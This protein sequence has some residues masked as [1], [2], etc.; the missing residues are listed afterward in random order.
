[1]APGIP[2]GG[3]MSPGEID[4][5]DEFD[6]DTSISDTAKKRRDEEVARREQAA[7]AEI[8]SLHRASGAESQMCE[9]SEPP[10]RTRAQPENIRGRVAVGT[11]PRGA[12]PARPS[13]RLNPL[14]TAARPARAASPSPLA[15]AFRRNVRSTATPTAN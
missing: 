1:M 6:V 14:D 4:D 2:G 12:S 3:G 11:P 15:E 5:V 7:A 10:S 13:P 8:D 9:R